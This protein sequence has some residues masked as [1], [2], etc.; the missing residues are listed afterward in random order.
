MDEGNDL[1][2]MTNRYYDS[3][4]GRFLQKD[5]IGFAGGTNLYAYAENQ[6]VGGIDP[7][8]LKGLKDYYY[9]YLGLRFQISETFK[10]RNSTPEELKKKAEDYYYYADKFVDV[11]PAGT[12]WSLMKIN[13]YLGYIGFYQGNYEEALSK[14]LVGGAKMGLGQIMEGASWEAQSL[15]G[16]SADVF[17]DDNKAV[18]SLATRFVHGVN[19]AAY[20]IFLTS[21]YIYDGVMDFRDKA[22]QEMRTL[23]RPR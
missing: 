18:D 20:G 11:T 13:Y 3:V 12:G 8:G 14:V 17:T 1:F 16:T 7:L 19:D 15:C 23:L 5:P 21:F 10:E 22:R 2:F 4:T 9:M 6:P